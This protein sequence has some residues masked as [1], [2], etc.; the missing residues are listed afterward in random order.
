MFARGLLQRAATRLY[1][2]DEISANDADPLLT[3]VEANRRSTLLADAFDGGL[4]FDIHLQG[5]TET[6]FFAW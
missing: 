6:V 3:R 5:P 1:F 2:P 4:R